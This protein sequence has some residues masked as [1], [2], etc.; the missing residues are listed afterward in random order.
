MFNYNLKQKIKKIQAGSLRFSDSF[1]SYERARRILLLCE[2][3]AFE[4]LLPQI[5]AFRQAGKELDVFVIDTK[6]QKGIAPMSDTPDYVKVLTSSDFSRR[7]HTPVA[8]I[9]KLLQQCRYDVM[10]D[11]TTELNYS[12]LYLAYIIPASYKMGVKKGDTNPYQ[13]M[14]QSTQPLTPSDI[15]EN[16]LFYWKKIDIKENNS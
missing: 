10:I 2:R 3:D 15:W 7:T 8:N 13:L 1:Q 9:L 16:L 11:V 5:E 12:T 14:I 6:K 4:A